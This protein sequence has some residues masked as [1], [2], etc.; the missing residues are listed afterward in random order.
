MNKEFQIT[1][2]EREIRE[3]KIEY[4][5]NHTNFT[6]TLKE[7]IKEENRLGMYLITYYNKN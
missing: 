4:K 5:K 7:K 2:I 1:K 6:K 3:K